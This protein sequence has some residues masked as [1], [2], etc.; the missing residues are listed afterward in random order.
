MKMRFNRKKILK[1]LLDT[2]LKN[3]IASFL[4]SEVLALSLSLLISGE[5]SFSLFVIAGTCGFVIA[6]FISGIV[7]S[8]RDEIVRQNIRLEQLTEELQGANDLLV[9]QNQELDAFA[10]TVAHDLKTP[11]TAIQGYASLVSAFHE[12]MS[13]TEREEKLQAIEANVMR[14]GRIIDEILLLSSIRRKDEVVMSSLGMGRIVAEVYARLEHMV[15]EYEAD[16]VVP[17]SWPRAVGY[18]PWVEEIWSNYVSN[19][20]KYGG[21]PPQVVLGYTL[22]AA[23]DEVQFWVQD[24]GAGL[25]AAEKEGLFTPFTRLEEGRAEGHGLGLSIVQRIVAKLGGRVGVIDN[26]E[27]EGSRFYFTLPT[28]KKE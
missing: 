7:F 25:T 20:L 16:W 4:L 3:A 5:V 14:M 19:A 27:G 11:L 6:Y 28:S 17:E 8:Y 12:K 13:L 15:V 10:H 1:T 22:L 26:P 21:T 23:G 18:G 24:N 2:P 9:E